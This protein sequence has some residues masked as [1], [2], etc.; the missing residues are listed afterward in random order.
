LAPGDKWVFA[1]SI[2]S[3]NSPVLGWTPDKQNDPYKDASG[4]EHEADDSSVFVTNDL[5]KSSDNLDFVAGVMAH[6]ATHS[7]IEY[8]IEATGQTRN[9]I[10][11]TFAAAEEASADLVAIKGVGDPTGIIDEHKRQQLN[12]WNDP[13]TTF[14]YLEDYYKI[15]LSDIYL[16]VYQR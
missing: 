5:F 7:W 8:K 6:E 2:M 3:G 13:R 4:T 9:D 10:D 16:L 15:D 14:K 11:L 12:G 1:K